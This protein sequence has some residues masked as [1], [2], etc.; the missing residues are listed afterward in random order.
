MKIK[1]FLL[2]TVFISY[3]GISQNLVGKVIAVKDGDTIEILVDGKPLRIR[4]SSIDCPEKSQAFGMAAKQFTSDFCF[5]K[6]VLAKQTDTDKYGRIVAFVYL[7]NGLVLNNALVENGFAWHYTRY[8][9]DAK[10]NI[11]ES[12]ARA[13]KLG[14]WAGEN[15]I[16]PWEFRK[17]DK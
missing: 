14:L 5:G 17:L 13:K 16:A 8:S 10:L 15:P 6:E 3:T 2:L 7:T 11:L 9:A 12:N 1:L 4:L